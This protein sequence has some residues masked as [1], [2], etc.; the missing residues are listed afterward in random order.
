MA[1]GVHEAYRRLIAHGCAHGR[2]QDVLAQLADIRD[3]LRT[4]DP[5][6]LGAAFLLEQAGCERGQEQL[7]FALD[8]GASS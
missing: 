4:T 2:K 8:D 1:G 3:Y 7:A 6:E 5:L